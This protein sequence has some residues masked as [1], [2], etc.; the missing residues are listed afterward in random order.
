MTISDSRV[1]DRL[2]SQPADRSGV[3]P[4]ADSRDTCGRAR[5]LTVMSPIRPPWPLFLRLAFA[6][7]RTFPRLTES[8]RRLSFIHYA[9]WAL[10]RRV[11]FNGPPQ[12]VEDL[13]YTHLMFLSNFNGTWNQYIDAFSRILTVGMKVIWGSSYGFPGPIP[14]EPFKRYIR[15]N[16]LVAG[17]YYS[18]YP[19]ATVTMINSALAVRA[20]FRPLLDLADDPDTSPE[21]FAA[22]YRRFLTNAQ[23]H[24]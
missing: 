21:M 16:E 15:R 10:I 6:V 4:A 7:A 19:D 13:R 2:S 5:A 18:A 12:R 11:P 8:A 23:R 3:E 24:L 14:T 1:A 9:H 20:E 17:H 22:A